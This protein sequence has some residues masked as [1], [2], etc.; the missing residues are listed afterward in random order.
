MTNQI[1]YLLF[2]LNLS[3]IIGHSQTASPILTLNTSMHTSGINRISCDV[4]GK[5]ILTCSKDKTAKL[6]DSSTGKLI[7]TFRVPIDNGDK[8]FLYAGAISPDGKIVVLGGVTGFIG[9]RK[10]SIYVFDVTKNTLKHRISGLPDV[11][12]DLEFS[13]KGNYLVATFGD[14]GIR[15]FETTNWTIKS[16]FPDYGAECYS[17]AFDYSGRLATACFDGKIRLYNSNF[18]LIQAVETKTGKHPVSLA[19]S[20]N[21][22]LLAVGYDDSGVIQVFDGRSLKLL[23]EP[24]VTDANTIN[25]K[26]NKVSF[27][28][29]GMF[30]FAGGSYS[31]YIDGKYWCQVRIWSDKGK[32]GYVDISVSR[33]AITDIKSLPDNSFIFCSSNP[34]FGRMEI[35]GNR[36]FYNS[37]EMN[38]YNSTDIS[39][40]KIDSTGYI[41]GVTPC[42]K[43]TITFSISERKL[44]ISNFINGSSFTDNKDISVTDWFNTLNPTINGFITRFLKEN[45]VNYSVDISNDAKQIVFG[46]CWN[47]YCTDASGTIIWETPVQASAWGVNISDN[48]RVI[49]ATLGNGTI[50]WYR[51]SDGTL[52]FS[53]FLHPDNQRWILW[54]PNGDFDCSSG[55][56]D[57]IGWHINQ[58]LDKEA[59]YYPANHFYEKF[60]VLNLGSK[61]L[62]SKE[63]KVSDVSISNFKLP[64]FV[65]IL[66]PNA[67][68]R[69]FKLENNKLKSDQQNIELVVEVTDQGGA[70]DEIQL[71]QNSKLV[72]TTNRGFKLIEQKNSQSRKTFKIRLVNGENEIKVTAFNNQRTEAFADE[73]T[74]IY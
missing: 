45:E 26:V 18:G 9:S 37:A 23:Y 47:I 46:T 58:G 32:G 43:Q 63:M 13:I 61:I 71:Y 28:N 15:I 31:K 51:M 1:L 19:F 35:D 72:E 33:N 70:I 8:G 7:I 56:D 25:D 20:P 67:E 30:L 59:L 50:C 66:S 21:G 38:A 27:S 11:V 24:N 12:N 41:I 4:S 39:N 16:S 60:Y 52:L 5:L 34:D 57:L 44:K 14:G 74:I 42:D 17:A 22:S 36:I 3:F 48:G 64:P 73:I 40:L 65:K 62:T 29:D 10:N 54:S 2:V 69:G 6:W 53:L 68:I 55:S 49:V